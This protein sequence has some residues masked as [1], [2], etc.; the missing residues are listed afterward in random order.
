V[1]G[2]RHMLPQEMAEAFNQKILTFLS[3][4]YQVSSSA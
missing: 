3:V 2:A 4:N 1:P